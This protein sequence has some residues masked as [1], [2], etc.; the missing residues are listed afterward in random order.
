MA[1]RK[2]YLDYD[3]SY[4]DTIEF[5]EKSVYCAELTLP[6]F[7]YCFPLNKMVFGM[8]VDHFELHTFYVVHT[9]QR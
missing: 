5:P 2:I 4:I 1:I 7:P 8:T 6:T 3:L 9:Y